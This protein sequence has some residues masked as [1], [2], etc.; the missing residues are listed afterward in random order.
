MRIPF[1]GGAYSG[2]SSSIDTQSL[3]N[4]YVEGDP[5]DTRTPKYAVP[6]GGLNQVMTIGSGQGRALYAFNDSL[7]FAIVGTGFYLINPVTYTA[8]LKGT[9]ATSTGRCIMIDNG[10]NNGHQVM[11]VDGS[12]NGYVYD[13]NAGTF[14]QL[15][16]AT[17]GWPTG[18]SGKTTLTWQDGY[19]IFN[20]P[21]TGEF[22]WSLA[23]GFNTIP[24]LNFATAEA[25]PDN[26]VAV[27]S[28][29]TKLFLYGYRTTEVWYDAGL[30]NQAFVRIP[31]AVF[32]VGIAGPYALCCVD[33]SIVFLGITPSGQA[34]L[35]QQRGAGIPEAVSEVSLSWNFTTML[36]QEQAAGTDIFL[37][38]FETQGH[39]FVVIT[40]PTANV[41]YVWDVFTREWS[42]WQTFNGTS[43]GA[44]SPIAHAFFAGGASN[45]KNGL[46]F[47]LDLSGNLLSYSDSNTTDNTQPITRIIQSPH[48]YGLNKR[49]RLGRLE[50]ML[51]SATTGNQGTLSWSKDYGQTFPGS[52]TFTFNSNLSTRYYFNRLGRG[53][54][55]V[56]NFTTTSNP[57]VLDLLVSPATPEEEQAAAPK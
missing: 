31:G 54:D 8:T 4:F 7:L 10:A 52:T 41:T 1:I 38:T 5:K 53:R 39:A 55:W 16:N 27:I 19:G 35:F 28:D 34:R 40:F 36:A 32:P 43:Q 57:L 11:I 30:Q 46:H 44:W 56:F 23:Y 22:W 12:G 42:T 2:R 24:G 29:G 21:G 17:N 6:R 48:L 51:G 13:T 20:Q 50:L 45:D 9:L 47:F 18:M 33:N 15:T 26:L 25:S 14:V 49:I 3:V 37:L